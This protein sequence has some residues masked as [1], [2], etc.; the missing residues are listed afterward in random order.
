MFIKLNGRTVLSYLD[1][2]LI[3]DNQWKIEYSL[4]QQFYTSTSVVYEERKL[5]VI[6]YIWNKFV[7]LKIDLIKIKSH[8]GTLIWYYKNSQENE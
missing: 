3:Y 6:F 4:L 7:K 5:Q 8:R 2:S 1:H